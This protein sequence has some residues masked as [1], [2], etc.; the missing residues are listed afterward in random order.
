MSKMSKFSNKQ[1]I[2][3]TQ[4]IHVCHIGNAPK[5][6]YNSEKQL[7]IFLEMFKIYFDLILWWQTCL[8]P[9]TQAN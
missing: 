1:T 2:Y 4:V 6:L 9:L 8:E 5:S 7:F 3:Q